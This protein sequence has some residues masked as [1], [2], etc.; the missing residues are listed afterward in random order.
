MTHDEAVA[1]PDSGRDW[2]G[3]TE[4]SGKQHRA[5][6]AQPFERV[7][8]GRQIWDVDQGQIGSVESMRKLR[9][10]NSVASWLF[11]YQST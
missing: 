7:A 6:R 3:G 9:R 1:P 4:I 2:Q 11:T 10:P 5:E 8:R